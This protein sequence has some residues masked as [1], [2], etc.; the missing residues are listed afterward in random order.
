MWQESHVAEGQVIAGYGLV[1]SVGQE[2]RGN[3]CSGKAMRVAARCVL[4][5]MAGRGLARHGAARQGVA[6]EE[7]LVGFRQ[8]LSR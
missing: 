6:G 4:A 8:G 3:V 5:G 1:W 7:R 2:W